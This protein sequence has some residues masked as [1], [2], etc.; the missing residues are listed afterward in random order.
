MRLLRFIA[1]LR[2]LSET[3]KLELYPP[4]FMMRIKV[5]EMRDNW[6][7]CRIR[8]PLN[9]LSRNP[10]GIMFGGW[11][12][13]LADPIAALA[14]ARV[15][16]GYSVW[17]RSMQIDF[18]AAG[19]SHLELRFEMSPEQE[20]AIRACLAERGRA[21]P[22]FEYGL[23]REDGVCCSR[24]INAVAIRPRGYRQA[25]RRSVDLTDL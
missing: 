22:R 16:P 8:L 9:T 5:V 17:T 11:Q 13:A 18:Q 24:I 1:G 19:S 3:R 21:T 20:D 25:R 4:F 10:G 7:Y 15:F 2:F 6:R 14:C 23:Y 12:A